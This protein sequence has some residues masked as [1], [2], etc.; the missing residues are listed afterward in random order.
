MGVVERLFVGASVAAPSARPLG[1]TQRR[2]S[3]PA[4]GKVRGVIFGRLGNPAMSI[5]DLAIEAAPSVF[6]GTGRDGILELSSPASNVDALALPGLDHVDHLIV[7]VRKASKDFETLLQRYGQPAPALRHY[8]L[9]QWR[10]QKLA[11]AIEAFRAALVLNAEDADLWR[12]LAGA[13]DGSGDAELAELCIRA[14][15][16]YQPDNARS[17]LLL[18]NLDS[19]AGRPDEAQS[20]FDHAIELDPTLGDA[21]F[22][23]GLLHFAQMRL[24]AA[25]ASLSL[26][27]ANGY[28]NAL[29]FAK[30]WP[31][32]VPS[33]RLRG[34]LGS[35]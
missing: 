17:W 32:S 35:V 3:D 31:S 12:D 25:L 19:R 16:R 10:D 27:I 18:A 20:A 7:S 15:L 24:D 6:D 4:W 5:G 29:G 30:S 13:Y 33:C 26:A 34:L 14:S 22:G 1:R 2:L 21:H 23:L 8:G 28:A 11:P 9:I